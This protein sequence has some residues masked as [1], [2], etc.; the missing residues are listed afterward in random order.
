VASH[1]DLTE[2]ADLTARDNLAA[3]DNRVNP[4]DHKARQHPVP[5]ASA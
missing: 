2:D 1:L 3:C 4:E 5:K